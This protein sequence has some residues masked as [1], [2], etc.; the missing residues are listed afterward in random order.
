MPEQALCGG[1]CVRQCSDC[2][3]YD[4]GML[5][6]E[7]VAILLC[8]IVMKISCILLN[9]HPLINKREHCGSRGNVC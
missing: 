5:L 4:L 8:G 7:M 1:V 3:Q 6:Y 2:K 9:F